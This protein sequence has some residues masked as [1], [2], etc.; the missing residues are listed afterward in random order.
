MNWIFPLGFLLSFVG[1]V[2]ALKYQTIGVLLF[3]AG[4]IM[5]VYAYYKMKRPPPEEDTAFTIE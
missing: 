5:C 2:L 3:I 4:L 1:F